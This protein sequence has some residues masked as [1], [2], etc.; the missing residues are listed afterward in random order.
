M[1]QRGDSGTG[2]MP[3]TSVAPGMTATPSMVRQARVG[4]SMR[5]M[6]YEARIPIVTASWKSDTSVPRRPAGA[7]SA[8]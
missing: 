8:M 1:S 4:A 6:T 2:S 3:N 5:S 7:S